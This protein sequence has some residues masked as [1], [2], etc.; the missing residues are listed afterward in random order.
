MNATRIILDD[1]PAEHP[2][3]NAVLREIHAEHESGRPAT[4][5]PVAR[6]LI[7]RATYNQLGNAWHG[8]RFSVII[9]PE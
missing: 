4:W 7:G 6:W 9:T 5:K 1:L 8:D 3:R 2:L